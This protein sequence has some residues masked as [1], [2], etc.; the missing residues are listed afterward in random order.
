M[1]YGSH[2]AFP[3]P[4]APFQGLTKR[5]YM[6]LHILTHLDTASGWLPSVVQDAVKVADYLLRELAG[7]T[8][9]PK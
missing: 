1:N 3:V 7:E 4:N 6:A 9:V 5:E 8:G 2:P